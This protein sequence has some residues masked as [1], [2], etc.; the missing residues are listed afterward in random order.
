MAQRLV[1]IVVALEFDDTAETT[2]ALA[3]SLASA[4]GAELHVCH[5]AKLGETDVRRDVTLASAAVERAHGELQSFLTK[6]FGDANHPLASRCELHVGVGSPAEQIIQLAADVEADVIVLGTH[7]RKGVARLV[8][9]SVSSEV[10]RNA[11][12][13]VLV[14]RATDF[15]GIEKTP[16]VEPPL[17]E[18]QAPMRPAGRLVRYR[19]QPF[20]VYNANLFPTGISRKAVR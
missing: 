1:R 17:A 3:S 6:A 14:A 10:F 8:L 18:G 16:D 9:G 2:W 11:P 7:E 13:S 19:S 5:V 12:C 20:S 4:Q 15:S